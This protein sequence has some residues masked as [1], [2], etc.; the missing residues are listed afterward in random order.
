MLAPQVIAT[1]VWPR[2]PPSST[3]CLIA[4]TP[5]APAGSMM[6]RVSSKTSLIAAQTASVS[7]T[8]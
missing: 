5:S 8:M 7:T 1:S 2:A 3:Y 6:L 4:A